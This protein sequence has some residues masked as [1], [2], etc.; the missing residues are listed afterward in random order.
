[1][2]FKLTVL[3]QQLLHALFWLE[4][5]FA[6]DI[7]I[8]RPVKILALPIIESQRSAGTQSGLS[9]K[10]SIVAALYLSHRR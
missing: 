6:R 4:L 8:I 3:G 7:N 9:P 2:G 10:P 1:M 5:C